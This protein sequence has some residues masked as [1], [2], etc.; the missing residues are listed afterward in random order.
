MRDQ[1]VSSAVVASGVA[2]D[3]GRLQG[4]EAARSAKL[5]RPPERLHPPPNLELIPERAVLVEHEDRLARRVG[6]RRRA[7]GVQLHQGQQSMGFGLVRRDGGEHAAHAK[8]FVAELG[9]QPVLA[10][11]RGVAFVEDEVDDLQHRGEPLR[12]FFALRRLIGQPRVPKGS[13]SRARCAG[14]SS[15]PATGRPWRSPRSSGRRSSAAPAPRGP[16]AT[17]AGDRR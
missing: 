11:R 9:T 4:I 15:H 3:N 5:A 7:R 12:Q 14:R 16:H 1:S 13:A 2:G 17:D 6:T 10:A 8:R